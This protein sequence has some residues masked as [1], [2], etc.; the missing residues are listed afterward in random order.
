MSW[1]ANLIPNYLRY[2][3]A[4]LFELGTFADDPPTAYV[5]HRTLWDWLPEN[6]KAIH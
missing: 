4:P 1:L 3:F 2:F 5:F 6:H